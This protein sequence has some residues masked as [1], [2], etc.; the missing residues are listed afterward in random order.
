MKFFKLADFEP[1]LVHL[2][3]LIHIGVFN[4]VYVKEAI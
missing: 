3:A 2:S 1:Y 4:T